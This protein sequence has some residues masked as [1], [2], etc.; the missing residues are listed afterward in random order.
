[1]R[2]TTTFV[3]VA[4]SLL[5]VGQGCRPAAPPIELPSAPPEGQPQAAGYK[6]QE[7]P[8]T[9]AGPSPSESAPE[10]P[11]EKNGGTMQDTQTNPLYKPYYIAYSAE[12]A[13]QA[14]A[15]G[16]PIVYYFWA[17]WCPI[18]RADEPIIK[19]RIENSGLPIAGFRVNFDTQSDLKAKYRIPYQHTTVFLNAKGEEVAR[20]NGPV[21][22]A[23]FNAGLA[24]AAK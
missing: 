2:T 20:L 21:G 8:A 3:F 13:A 9:D 7:E 10:E 11:A 6:P 23:E 19:A 18:C 16:R 15:E 12:A 5:L 17:A 14:R 22:D 1:M 4:A 24:R